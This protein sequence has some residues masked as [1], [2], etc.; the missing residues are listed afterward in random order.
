MQLPFPTLLKSLCYTNCQNAVTDLFILRAQLSRR[1][2]EQETEEILSLLWAMLSAMST[3]LPVQARM[4]A[5][6]NLSGLAGK[7]T[8]LTACIATGLIS[9][10]LHSPLQCPLN[11]F[12]KLAF[13]QY[14]SCNDH[15]PF[16]TITSVLSN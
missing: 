5:L 14:H 10:L 4:L 3:C 7:Q 15:I 13:N 11:G 12:L 8:A 16:K 6:I 9:L 2:F 1:H